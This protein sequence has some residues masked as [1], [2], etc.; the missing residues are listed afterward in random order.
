MRNVVTV[1]GGGGSIGGALCKLLASQVRELRIV[2][3]SELSLYN[4]VQELERVPGRVAR[5]VPILGNV[6][7]AGRMI[8][9]IAGAD[10]VI[11]AAA[12]KH[13]PLCEQNKVQAIV[14]NVRGSV[15]VAH[16]ANLEGVQLVHISTD[17]AVKP[18]SVMGKTKR[19][20]E[21]W[22]LR[23]MRR[24][25]APMSIVRFGNVLGSSGSVLPLW[26]RQIAAGGPITVTDRRCMRYFMSVEE[27]CQLVL[28]VAELREPGLFVLD[29]GEPLSIW[30]MAHERAARALL[31]M[32]QQVDVVETGLRPGEKLTEELHCYGDVQ[33][34]R[35]ARVRKVVEP[36]S[37]GDVHVAELLSA[38]AAGSE[39]EAMKLLEQVVKW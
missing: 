16:V 21:L 14:N 29:M 30:A 17:K 6:C 34:T 2:G 22:L 38:A 33:P 24:A 35:Y 7:D 20:A 26:D 15:T 12:H 5:V 36:E 28:N 31:S 23:A 9:C 37:T 13:V 10:L 11:H 18:A 32:G 8:E 39:H 25:S 19:A 3:H 1:T 4:I 27:A